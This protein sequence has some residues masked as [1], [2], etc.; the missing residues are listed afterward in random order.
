MMKRACAWVSLTLA[1]FSLLGCGGDSSGGG[2]P[3]VATTAVT[4]TDAPSSDLA[5][6]RLDLTQLSLRDSAGGVVA[7]LPTTL[8]QQDLLRLRGISKLLNSVHVPPGTYVEL[9][10]SYQRA[11]ARD[12]AGNQLT[13]SPPAGT[14]SQAL[15]LVVPA[16]AP[17]RL[18]VDI[19]VD[20]SLQSVQTGAGGSLSFVPVLK[21]EL[22]P[23]GVRGLEDFKAR[24]AQVGAQDLVLEVGAGRLSVVFASGAVLL[25]GT[26]SVPVASTPL[27]SIL[28][29]GTLLEVRGSF[30]AAAR[31]VRAHELEVD[32]GTNAG[33]RVRGVV[34]A[35]SAQ[36]IT[37]LVTDPKESSFSPGSSHTI[38]LSAQTQFS[39]DGPPTTAAT[40]SDVAIGQEVQVAPFSGT[41]L[42]VRLRDTR[43]AGRILSVQGSTLSIAPTSFERTGVSRLPGV[44]DPVSVTLDAGAPNLAVVGAK[45]SLE[46]HFK[47]GTFVGK[48]QTLELD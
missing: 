9:S 16:A 48:S 10:F 43:L 35:V 3:A 36:S 44:A 4:L 28:T 45:I 14:V 5:E 18:E 25:Q 37:F 21:A 12:L 39:L 17:N 22:D 8:P 2:A 34:Q 6:L 15:N 7:L 19:R 1:L 20:D 13:V 42:A 38:A 30:D 27:D 41:A 31:A 32:D 29:V 46:G 11:T 26:N 33:P 47:G 23:S 40:L 24:V